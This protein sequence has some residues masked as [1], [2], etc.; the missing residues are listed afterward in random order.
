MPNG[1]EHGVFLALDLGGTNLRVCEVKLNG[2]HTFDMQAQKY[3]VSED[4]KTVCTHTRP[5][6]GAVP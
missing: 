5:A 1:K 4:L 6:S 2:D 3:R